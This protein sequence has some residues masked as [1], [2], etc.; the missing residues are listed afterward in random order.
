MLAAATPEVMVVVVIGY[1]TMKLVFEL[2]GPVSYTELLDIKTLCLYLG[3]NVTLDVMI[4]MY[5]SFNHLVDMRIAN[6]TF[7]DVNLFR[8]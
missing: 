6:N 1:V 3:S 5:T 4:V 8:T 7:V 2:S